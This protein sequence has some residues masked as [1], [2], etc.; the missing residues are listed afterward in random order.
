MSFGMEDCP[1]DVKT[2]EFK[3][4]YH[5]PASTMGIEF[6]VGKDNH[7]TDCESYIDIDAD[8]GSY[9]LHIAVKMRGEWQTVEVDAI[10]VKIRGSFERSGF[11]IALQQTGLLTLPFYGKIR[12]PYEEE[13][14]ALQEQSRP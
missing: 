1:L 12:S 2:P 11:I 5:E 9:P 6:G 7:K 13:N 14:D 3:S 8:N 4:H 10:R